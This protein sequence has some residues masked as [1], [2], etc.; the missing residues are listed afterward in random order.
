MTTPFIAN[1]SVGI[2]DPFIF[3]LLLVPLSYMGICLMGFTI[4]SIGSR[5]GFLRIFLSSLFCCLLVF[6]LLIPAELSLPFIEK[7]PE[8]AVLY[9]GL[10]VSSGYEWP[11]W[12]V[13]CKII[14]L[15]MG[16]LVPLWIGKVYTKLS[17]LRSI[18]VTI[19][20]AGASAIT[21]AVMFLAGVFFA[22][23]SQS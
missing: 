22:I 21:W 10:D 19:G 5:R 7:A 14:L 11:L 9:E 3:A 15:I 18:L 6:C 13:I 1:D 23:M 8:L 16:V 20:I 4:G 17:W 12:V 2:I